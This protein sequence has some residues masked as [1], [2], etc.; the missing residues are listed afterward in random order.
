MRQ[1]HFH[2]YS[3]KIAT[4][5]SRYYLLCLFIV[6]V[7]MS[8]VH[9]TIISY[10]SALWQSVVLYVLA[11]IVLILANLAAWTGFVWTKFIVSQ[12]IPT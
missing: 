12:T 9:F 10:S 2:Q 8:V 6:L 5:S 11:Y 1:T 7:G 4:L 3:N